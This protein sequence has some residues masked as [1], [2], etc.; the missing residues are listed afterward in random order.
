MVATLGSLQGNLVGNHRSSIFFRSF[1]QNSKK[2]LPRSRWF[3]NEELN[4]QTNAFKAK[5]FFNFLSK[6]QEQNIVSVA[7][8]ERKENIFKQ[9]CTKQSD[10]LRSNNG[11]TAD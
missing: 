3:E 5:Y 1:T 11:S 4:L 6:Y 8:A 2:T 10:I 9:G 7:K